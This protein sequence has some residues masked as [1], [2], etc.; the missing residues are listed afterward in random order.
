MISVVIPAFNEQDSIASTVESVRTTLDGAALGPYEVVVVDDGSSDATARL[1][2]DAGA[3]VV[4][5]PHNVGYGKSLKDG[6]LAAR[7]DTIVITDADGTYP[8]AAIPALVAEYRRGHDMV[9]GARM[10]AHYHESVV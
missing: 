4:T 7:F 10:G 5:H 2:A 3:R 9:V 1:A 6:I 8:I